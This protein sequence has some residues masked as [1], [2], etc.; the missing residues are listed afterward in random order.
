[1]RALASN[2][3]DGTWDAARIV[4]LL[5]NLLTNALQHGDAAGIVSV[6]VSTRVNSVL[7]EISNK[8]EPISPNSLGTLF[9]P[10][11]RRATTGG[12]TRKPKSSGLGLGLF[13][14]SQIARAHGGD[15]KVVSTREA[16]TIFSLELPK[17]YSPLR[18]ATR[19]V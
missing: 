1:M 13:I 12:R 3:I 18:A 15:I 16:G 6:T 17:S 9:D 19:A 11:F 14:A 4:Q 5:T 2:W 10:L 8:G 7:V